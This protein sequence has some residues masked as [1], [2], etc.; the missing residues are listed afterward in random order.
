MV[1]SLQHPLATFQRII[2]SGKPRKLKNR[3]GR[4]K[5]PTRAAKLLNEEPV[6]VNRYPQA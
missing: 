1:R 4:G 6:Y 2:L 5:I 3:K